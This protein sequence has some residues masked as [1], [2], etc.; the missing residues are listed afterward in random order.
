MNIPKTLLFN[1]KQNFKLQVIFIHLPQIS[2]VAS[3]EI[4][5]ENCLSKSGMNVMM[6]ECCISA[7]PSSSK[8][9]KELYL[10]YELTVWHMKTTLGN[11]ET[12]H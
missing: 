4:P 10:K 5:T 6:D 7:K 8:E 1:D 12:P 2:E 11:F 3:D 9:L